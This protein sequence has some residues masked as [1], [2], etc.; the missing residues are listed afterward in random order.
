LIQI[1][2]AFAKFGVMGANEKIWIGTWTNRAG[3]LGLLMPMLAVSMLWAYG[4]R[5]NKLKYA[6]P[7]A[8]LFALVTVS[9]EKR[10]VLVIMPTLVAFL[11]VMVSTPV[12]GAWC[13]HVPSNASNPAPW[14]D[15]LL[16]LLVSAC[17]VTSAALLAIPSLDTSSRDYEN[18]SSRSVYA[19]IVEYMTRDFESPMNLSKMTVEE[20]RNIQQGRLRMWV[21]ALAGVSE[22]T[23]PSVLF[24]EGGG[25]LMEHRM[26][27][28]KGR[29]VMFERL[30]LRGPAPTGLRHFF[31]VGV[32]GLSMMAVWFVWLAFRLFRK[33]HSAFTLGVYGAWLLFMFDYFVYSQ[34]GWGGG[35]FAPILFLLVAAALRGIRPMA[36]QN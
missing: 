15:A 21:K 2:V 36:G 18:L 30:R 34:V 3:Q 11:I 32:V 16:A 27:A 12:I 17:V 24:G 33:S 14:R 20:N 4:L 13:G 25:W 9:A 19:Y 7:I 31:E 29:D 23:L 6:V 1:P 8:T 26:L 10:A 5:W 35:V 28:G 22:R